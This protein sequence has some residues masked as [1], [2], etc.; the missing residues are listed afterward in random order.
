MFIQTNLWLS[1]FQTVLCLPPKEISTFADLEIS[2]FVA[3]QTETG[4]LCVHQQFNAILSEE[5]V[6]KYAFLITGHLAPGPG[7]ESIVRPQ[8]YLRKGKE[9]L[10]D[11]IFLQ[12]RLSSAVHVQNMALYFAPEDRTGQGGGRVS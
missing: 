2:I 12:S 6:H 10:K 5:C 4:P 1:G 3:L 7:D 11:C 8:A 9:F